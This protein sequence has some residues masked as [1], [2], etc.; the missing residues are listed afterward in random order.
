[1]KSWTIEECFKYGHILKNKG[2]T[3]Y[4][5]FLIELHE[6]NYLSQEELEEYKKHKLWQKEMEE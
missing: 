6:K 2:I 4:E 1:M 5:K 3:T